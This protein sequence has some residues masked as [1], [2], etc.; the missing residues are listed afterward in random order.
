MVYTIKIV[1]GLKI[2][3]ISLYSIIKMTK[4][5]TIEE[6]SIRVPSLD[7]QKVKEVNEAIVEEEFYE[8][9]DNVIYPPEEKKSSKPSIWWLLVLG[10]I[11]LFIH[12]RRS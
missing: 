7:L 4:K 2:S 1:N 5:V 6:P 3:H 10:G 9:E 11:G 12:R 8:P